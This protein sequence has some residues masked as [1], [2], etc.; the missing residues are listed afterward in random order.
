MNNVRRKEIKK[1]IAK[2]ETVISLIEEI[3]GDLE[4]IQEE[5]QEAFDNMPEGLQESERGETMQECIDSFDEILS[6][7]N[8]EIDL[9][10]I[11]EKLNEM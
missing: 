1:S 7:L 11:I 9:T 8:D 5:E 3:A 6:V 4:L 2:L 10:E